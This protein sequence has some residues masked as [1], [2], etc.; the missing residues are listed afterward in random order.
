MGNVEIN[1]IDKNRLKMKIIITSIVASSLIWV[2][3]FFAKSEL[4]N[5]SEW[6]FIALLWTVLLVVLALFMEDSLWK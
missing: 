4:R 3:L 5:P 1:I 6:W 2:F